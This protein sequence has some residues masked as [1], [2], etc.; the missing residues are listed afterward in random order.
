[1]WLVAARPDVQLWRAK[2]RLSCRSHFQIPLE[3]RKGVCR[4][5][6]VTCHRFFQTISTCCDGLKPWNFPVTWSVSATSPWQVTD[7]RKTSQWHVSREW[8][9][10]FRPWFWWCRWSRFQLGFPP[11]VFF[12]QPRGSGFCDAYPGDPRVRGLLTGKM[13]WKPLDFSG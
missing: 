2:V 6:Q 12:I 3:R 4:W 8:N 5:L 13:D 11:S 7:F 10:G 1:V 9:L